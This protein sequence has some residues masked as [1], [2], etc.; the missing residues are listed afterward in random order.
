[1]AYTYVRKH[2]SDRNFTFGTGEFRDLARYSSAIVL[3]M[4]ALLICYEGVSRPLNPVAISFNEANPI[5]GLG[6]ADE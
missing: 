1:L 2:A 5:A 3:A 4:I 6:L